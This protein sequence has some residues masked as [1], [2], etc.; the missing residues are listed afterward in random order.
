MQ[1]GYFV[2][3]KVLKATLGSLTKE[4]VHLYFDKRMYVLFAGP[5]GEGRIDGQIRALAEKLATPVTAW[6]NP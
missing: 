3:R 5:A 1:L 4:A 6:S 2:H